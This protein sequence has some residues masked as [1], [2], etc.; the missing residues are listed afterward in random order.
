MKNV[1]IGNITYNGIDTVRLKNADTN[2]YNDW[3]DKVPQEKTVTDNGEVIPDDGKYLSK[4]IVN[5]SKGEDA[6]AKSSDI[7]NGKTAYVSGNKI[8]G[9]IR[10]YSGEVG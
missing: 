5:V 1:K 3:N 6:T 7:L 8:T 2:D 9:T 10:T 4:V